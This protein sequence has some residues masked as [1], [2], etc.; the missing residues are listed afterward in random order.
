M[1]N[2]IRIDGLY[3]LIVSGAPI[4]EFAAEAARLL[5]NPVLI[6][7]CDLTCLGCSDD[8][9]DNEAWRFMRSRKPDST[10]D[11]ADAIFL[12][13]VE[14]KIRL[15]NRPVINSPSFSPHRFLDSQITWKGTVCGMVH[16]LEYNRPFQSSDKRILSEIV[17][18]L[19]LPMNK[20]GME[21]TRSLSSGELALR[22]LLHND[23]L[24]SSLTKSPVFTLMNGHSY[25]VLVAQN[26][27]SADWNRPLSTAASVLAGYFTRSQSIVYQDKIVVL[28]Q[29]PTQGGKINFEWKGIEGMLRQKS[30]VAA[31]SDPFTGYK[32]LSYFHEQA[33]NA[34]KLGSRFSRSCILFHYE[35]VGLYELFRA[36]ESYIMKAPVYP[37]LKRLL[38]YDEENG[39]RYFK[40]LFIYL[41]NGENARQTAAVLSL[42]KNTVNYRVNRIEEITGEDLHDFQSLFRLQLSIRI[43]YYREANTFAEKYDIPEEV[44]AWPV[45]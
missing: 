40:D 14:E 9:V 13:S 34:L 29:V 25:V 23:S 35:D 38:D 20:C 36:A 16:V 30:L 24:T 22:Y 15:T 41:Q 8:E 4:K 19:A 21:G 42:H 44:L 28:A 17:R 6:A 27:D 31:V 37:P 43:L 7:D 1:D 12:E 45:I 18:A 39:T 32:D 26:A 2:G 3:E 11:I 5:E 33:C 10:A